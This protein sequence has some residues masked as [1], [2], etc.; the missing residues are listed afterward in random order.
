MATG[1]AVHC[2]HIGRL[3][4]WAEQAAEAGVLLILFVGGTAS[5]WIVVPHGGAE[6]NL[7]TNP[8]AFAAP[9]Q[10]Q[11]S[12]V[13]DIATASRLP[14]P[15]TWPPAVPCYRQPVT[16]AMAWR[17]SPRSLQPISLALPP[18]TTRG[19]ASLPSRSIQRVRRSR[20]LL[21]S[22]FATIQ[23]LRSTR[24]AQP[25]GEVLIPGDAERRSRAELRAFGVDVPETTW[26]SILDAAARLGLEPAE[27]SALAGVWPVMSNPPMTSRP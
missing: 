14:T 12:I 21:R 25:D 27:V 24:P 3:G 17:S 18:A 23:R 1:A 16:R 6:P 20:S 7:H 8:L 26:N 15:T 9:S 22:T 2:Q 11:D 19:T 5:N 13:L 4:Q 10:D